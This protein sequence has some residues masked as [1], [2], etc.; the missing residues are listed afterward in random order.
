VTETMTPDDFDAYMR[1]LGKTVEVVTSPNGN[2]F[3][4]IKSVEI[5]TGPRM[6]KTCDVA[7]ARPTTNPY[8]VPAAIHTNPAVARMDTTGPLK[9]QNSELGPEWQYWSRRYEHPLSPQFIWAHILTVLGE[10]VS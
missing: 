3:T 8:T 5:T 4:L 1:G 7:L 2:P 10:D 6:G 9:T